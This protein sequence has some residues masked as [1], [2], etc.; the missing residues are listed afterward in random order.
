MNLPAK[1]TSNEVFDTLQMF[2]EHHLD[3]RTVTLGVNLLDCASPSVQ[4]TCER[5]VRKLLR[6]GRDL[7][8]TVTAVSQELGI[9]IINKRISCSVFSSSIP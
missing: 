4:E 6:V 5:V 3:I 7:V 9:P 1:L 2:E 8:P